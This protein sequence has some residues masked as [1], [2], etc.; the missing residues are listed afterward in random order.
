M[1]YWQCV[2]DLRQWAD[3]YIDSRA[4]QRL[5]VRKYLEFLNTFSPD[6]KPLCPDR[7]IT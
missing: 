3:A 2:R 4:L 6:D 1:F 5:P 7:K